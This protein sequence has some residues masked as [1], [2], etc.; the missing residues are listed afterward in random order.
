VI[1]RRLF[2]LALFAFVLAWGVACRNDQGI[3]DRHRQTL[4]DENE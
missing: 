2:C 1:V 4:D 3:I